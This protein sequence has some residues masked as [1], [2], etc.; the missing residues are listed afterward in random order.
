MVIRKAELAATVF[1]Q[2]RALGGGM[3]QVIIASL[4]GYDQSFVSPKVE[5]AA[6]FG[7]LV[8]RLLGL[9]QLVHP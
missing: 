4:H 3:E 5:L 8:T 7:H 1:A 6:R 2:L 9:C